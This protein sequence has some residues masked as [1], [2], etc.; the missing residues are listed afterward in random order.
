MLVRKSYHKSLP[1][2]SKPH[3]VHGDC[4]TATVK[5]N[6][7]CSFGGIF[8][9][10]NISWKKGRTVC[11]LSWVFCQ[12]QCKAAKQSHKTKH[13][14]GSVAER[15]ERWT[16][17]SEAPNSNPAVGRVVRSWVKIT[18]GQWWL[19]TLKKI[20][21]NYLSAFDKKIKNPGSKFN[22]GL[23]LTDV[24]TTGPSWPLA[25]FVHGSQARVQ[26]LGHA[27]K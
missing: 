3:S 19:D 2:N 12:M 20:R 9:Y 21:E 6:T 14:G 7:S 15:L 24:R 17:D 25:G 4:F 10:T 8:D 5:F 22:P 26:I 18:Q 13:I 23:V 27:C 16:C 11:W 1:N